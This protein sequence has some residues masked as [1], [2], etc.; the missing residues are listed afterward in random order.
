MFVTFSR[1]LLT[2]T[3]KK[4]V[5]DFS[6]RSVTFQNCQQHITSP[7]YDMLHIRYQN[8]RCY[9]NI[10]IGASEAANNYFFGNRK[11]QMNR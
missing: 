10:A 11:I 7:A 1:L 5:T 6:N 2:F 9:I 4:M 3:M 8:R